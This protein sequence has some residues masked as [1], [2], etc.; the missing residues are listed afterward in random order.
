M[1]TLSFLARQHYSFAVCFIPPLQ[2]A[3]CKL[4]RRLGHESLCVL[5]SRLLTYDT[6]VVDWNSGVVWCYSLFSRSRL[7]VAAVCWSMALSKGTALTLLL[8]D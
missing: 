3:A 6:A 7:A 1:H 4:L 8:H 5:Q 2:K